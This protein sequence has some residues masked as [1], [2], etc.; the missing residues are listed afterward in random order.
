VIIP[1]MRVA[2]KLAEDQ[3]RWID[4]KTAWGPGRDDAFNL[5]K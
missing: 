5:P 1:K 3:L 4:D 2:L